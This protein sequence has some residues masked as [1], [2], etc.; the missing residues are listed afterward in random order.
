MGQSRALLAE[1]RGDVLCTPP[2]SIPTPGCSPKLRRP[3][4]FAS[5]PTSTAKSALRSSS[6]GQGGKNRQGMG[7]TGSLGSA[8]VH[9]T[10][11]GVPGRGSGNSCNI[12]TSCHRFRT[13]RTL[14]TRKEWTG[15]PASDAHKHEAPGPLVTTSGNS[16]CAQQ[17][18]TLCHPTDCSPPASSVRGIF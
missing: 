8:P 5:G 15:Q 11:L 4:P 13:H 1:A 16:R 14:E 10:H 6:R 3:L 7:R 9:T 12:C 18:E 17:G 2:H